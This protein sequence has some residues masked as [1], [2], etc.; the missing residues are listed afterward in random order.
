ML[1]VRNWVP[2]KA[3]LWDQRRLS[4]AELEP[5]RTNEKNTTTSLMSSRC[6]P[7][8]LRK[9]RSSFRIC[10]PASFDE[11]P[12]ASVHLYCRNRPLSFQNLQLPP[13]RV[14]A[15]DRKK[16]GDGDGRVSMRMGER[17]RVSVDEATRIRLGLAGSA[18]S[19]R[20]CCVRSS[21][22]T[23]VR[24]REPHLVADVY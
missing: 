13:M 3:P 2:W 15:R 23:G 14:K 12:H 11:T 9:R 16:E 1:S 17:I 8:N 5:R 21:R 22:C 18:E 6:G 4:R 20:T 10:S 19:M 24:R 7:T